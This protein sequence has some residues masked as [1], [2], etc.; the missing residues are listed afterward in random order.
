L[1]GTL[2]NEERRGEIRA[3]FYSPASNPRHST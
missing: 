2:K 1:V 3:V